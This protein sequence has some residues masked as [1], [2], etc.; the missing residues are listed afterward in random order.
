VRDPE[1]EAIDL[2]DDR[3]QLLAG[4]GRG[5]LDAVLGELR[6]R[7]QARERIPQPMGHA[8]RH[9]PDRGQLL[10]LH[11]LGAGLAE[12]LGHA[13]ESARQVADLVTGARLDRVVQVAGAD[14]RHRVPQLV[15]RVRQAAGNEPRC[16]EAGRERERDDTPEDAP[17]PVDDPRHL[18]ERRLDAE[19]ARPSVDL[20]VHVRQSRLEALHKLPSRQHGG[21]VVPSGIVQG[22]HA[23]RDRP[24]IRLDPADTVRELE[25][26]GRQF[27]SPAIEPEGHDLLGERKLFP[28]RGIAAQIPPDHL[29][30][31]EHGVFH[32]G[33]GPRPGQSLTQRLER[34][35]HERIGANRLNADQQRR[36]HHEREAQEQLALEGHSS[37]LADPSLARVPRARSG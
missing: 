22:E 33:V 7:A 4:G 1:I 28:G 19:L 29:G 17:F 23:T 20:P 5:A 24:D 26:V 25:L 31:V 18:R 8:G 12:L 36:D 21:R 14:H 11:E 2:L 15:E 13:G 35:A 34:A 10:G 32:F 6:G 9:L 3:A 27:R 16:H 30:L 37:K